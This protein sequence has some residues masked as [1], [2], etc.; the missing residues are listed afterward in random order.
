MK[1]AGDEAR[2][3]PFQAYDEVR[4]VRAAVDKAEE[5]MAGSK[6]V[7]SPSN[8]DKKEK[9]LQLLALVQ[10]VGGPERT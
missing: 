2:H 4:T 5:L 9:L 3:G 6:E 7:S 1:R 8:E 10:Y